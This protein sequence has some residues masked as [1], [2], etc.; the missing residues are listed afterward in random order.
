MEGD[1]DSL[2]LRKTRG[3]SHGSRGSRRNTKS[4]S[5]V[6]VSATKEHQKSVDRIL[7]TPFQARSCEITILQAGGCDDSMVLELKRIRMHNLAVSSETA[8]VWPVDRWCR[9][10]YTREAESANSGGLTSGRVRTACGFPEPLLWCRNAGRPS[11]SHGL[12]SQCHSVRC[13]SS[14]CC[15][16]LRENTRGLDASHAFSPASH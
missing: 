4:F 5:C 13:F 1:E 16:V 12:T 11:V 3:P 9:R 2:S 14:C 6:C 8:S 7:Y 15:T 10:R